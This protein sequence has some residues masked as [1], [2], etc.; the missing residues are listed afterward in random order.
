M[1]RLVSTAVVSRSTE[2][3]AEILEATSSLVAVGEHPR[4]DFVPSRW[5]GNES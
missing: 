4:R 3:H 1:A 5:L 2:R